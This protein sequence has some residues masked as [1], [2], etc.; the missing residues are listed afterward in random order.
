MGRGHYGSSEAHKAVTPIR[1]RELED[2]KNATK[3]TGICSGNAESLAVAFGVHL[4]AK[5]GTNKEKG[6][7]AAGGRGQG[8]GGPRPF[9]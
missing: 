1:N 7:G 3:D 5:D 4:Q 2:Q 6:A 9:F 8:W